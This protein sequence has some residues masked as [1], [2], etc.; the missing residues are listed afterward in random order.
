MTRPRFDVLG[1]GIIPLDLLFTVPHYPKPGQKLDAADITI[2][3]GGPVPNTLV[4]L[5]RLGCRTAC[6]AAVGDDLIGDL[7]IAELTGERVDASLIVRS[8]AR[9]AVAAGWIESG[10]GQRTIVLCR[11]LVVNP[12]D[13]VVSQ[14][15]DVRLVHLDGRDM[16]ASLKLARWARRRDIPVSFD[17]GSM[18]ND[19][20]ALL[21]LTDHLVVADT[22]AFG[23]TGFRTAKQAIG[24]LRRH[25]R[26]TIVVTEGIRGSTGLENGVW[27]RQ[28]AYKVRAVDTTGAGDSYHAGYLYGLLQRRPLAERMRFASAC[29]A[30]KCTRPGAR[31]GAPTRKQVEQFL[32]RR[33]RPHA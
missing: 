25:C 13:I 29:A 19:V 27:V 14:L 20:S 28:A 12:A 3:G 23:F 22:F 18:R 9:S 32:K 1:L 31:T 6:I 5:A 7:S 26:G 17:I 8:A 2:Q 30:C 33:P 4:G 10:T 16:P 11:K 15:P 21:P 24:R